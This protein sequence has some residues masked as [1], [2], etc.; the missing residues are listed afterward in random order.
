MKAWT[1]RR[2]N[3]R[4]VFGVVASTAEFEREL[5]RGRVPIGLAAARARG[6]RIGRPRITV[7]ARKVAT[8]RAAGAFW[9]TIC[10]ETGL[11]QGYSAKGRSTRYQ[12]PTRAASCKYLRCD[13]RLRQSQAVQ[14]QLIFG[15]QAA[16]F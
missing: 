11:N 9:A 14:N 1:R 16:S 4:L 8:L 15:L 13:D 7:N 3:D 5:I 2:L 10:R 12:K 6:K